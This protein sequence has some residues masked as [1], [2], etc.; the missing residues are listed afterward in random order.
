MSH[1]KQ[2]EELLKTDV[3]I[4]VNDTLK[5][6]EEQIKK[7]NNKPLKEELNYMKE[8]KK[9]FDEVLIDIKND[10]ITQNQALDILEGLEDMKIEN[11]EV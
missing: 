1:I 6:L 9:Y 10:S 7:K 11:Q 2:L 4:E 3:L 8:V 5:E